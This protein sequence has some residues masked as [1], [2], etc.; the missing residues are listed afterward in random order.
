SDQERE[1]NTVFFSRNI[2]HLYDGNIETFVAPLEKCLIYFHATG[3]S[4]NPGLEYSFS[5]VADTV[6]HPGYGF[7]VIDCGYMPS[8]CYMYDVHRT[9][10]LKLFSNG[11]EVSTISAPESLTPEAMQKLM[12]MSPVLNKPLVKVGEDLMAKKAR[13]QQQT[14]TRHGKFCW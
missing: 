4:P 9:P 6:N 8:L 5:K 1:R 13:Q 10:A 7:G 3:T 14:P 11:F 12:V 2:T